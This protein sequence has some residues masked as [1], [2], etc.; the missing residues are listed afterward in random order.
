M[1]LSRL[2]EMPDRRMRKDYFQMIL[3]PDIPT[4]SSVS[5]ESI[6]IKPAKN[7]TLK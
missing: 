3:I 5:L 6:C 4:E 7:L 2:E 1:Q